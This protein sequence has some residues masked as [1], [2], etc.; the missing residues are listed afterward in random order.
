MKTEEITHF[1]WLNFSSSNIARITAFGASDLLDQQQPDDRRSFYTHEWLHIWLRAKIAACCLHCA[2]LEQYAS[3]TNKC[4]GMIRASKD[5]FDIILMESPAA[6][7]FSKWIITFIIDIFCG[8]CQQISYY[9][10]IAYK[11]KFKL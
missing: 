3:S 1:K 6:V 2:T 4:I 7:V 10:K 11:F 8:F 5:R 9:N